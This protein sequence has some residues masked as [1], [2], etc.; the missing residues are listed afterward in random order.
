VIQKACAKK[1]EDRW[2]DMTAFASALAQA[3]PT[4]AGRQLTGIL[5]TVSGAAPE[6]DDGTSGTIV[7][8]DSLAPAKPLLNKTINV[9][10]DRPPDPSVYIAPKSKA[11]WVVLGIAAVALLGLGGFVMKDRLGAREVV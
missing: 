11:P 4:L 2:P 6:A 9:P 7:R 8:A 10:T 3:T 1:K 5:K